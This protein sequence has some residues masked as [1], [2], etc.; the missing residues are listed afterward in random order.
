[1]AAIDNLIAQVED[2][3]LRARLQAE[4]DRLTKE[5]EVGLFFE[6]HL[7]ELIPIYSANVR[8]G[9]LVALRGKVLTDVWHVLSVAKGKAD[10]LNRARG[11]QREVPVEDLV[12]VRQFGEPIFPSLVPIDRVK[13]GPK[14]APWHTIIEADNYHA[15]QLLEYLYADR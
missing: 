1:L 14:G 8:K 9:S 4:A 6:E 11:E 2:E 13:N 10:C 3:A 12:V 5:Q 7:P 15:M